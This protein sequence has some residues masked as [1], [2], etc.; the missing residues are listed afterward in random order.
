M[1][2]GRNYSKLFASDDGPA[3]AFEREMDGSRCESRVSGERER[4]KAQTTYCRRCCRNLL[5]AGR[6]S[7]TWS[8]D[9]WCD[10][11]C[12]SRFIATGSF[13]SAREVHTRN[14]GLTRK[15]GAR[16]RL[17][18]CAVEWSPPNN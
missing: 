2:R 4:E 15:L 1:S 9:F 13:Y 17:D 3:A 5:T 6:I 18:K 14:S 10:A 7:G 11:R 8:S 16:S 12:K